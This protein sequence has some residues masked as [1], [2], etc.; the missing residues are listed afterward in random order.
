MDKNE[1]MNKVTE[2]VM[3]DPTMRESFQKLY[4]GMSKIG[5][6]QEQKPDMIYVLAQKLKVATE[7]GEELYHYHPLVG[8]CLL[9]PGAERNQIIC[10]GNLL[11]LQ[12][13]Q[14]D[15]RLAVMCG[16]QDDFQIL[17]MK[18][19]EFELLQLLLDETVTAIMDNTHKAVEALMLNSA[20]TGADTISFE[21][22]YQ[23]IMWDLL[24]KSHGTFGSALGANSE[25]IEEI[26][27]VKYDRSVPDHG[28]CCGECDTED[29]EYEE[30][31]EDDGEECESAPSGGIYIVHRI[32]P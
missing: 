28:C 11:E 2:M 20:F 25:I 15:A 32:N 31:E 27:G 5:P 14:K 4:E 13:V 8:E 24:T 17:A 21:R 10:S 30:D 12:A 16:M 7:N 26:Q 9:F 19:D 29:E 6:A 3:G 1:F 18:P 23:N 22:L